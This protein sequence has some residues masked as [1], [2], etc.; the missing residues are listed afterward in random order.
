MK[1]TVCSL[2]IAWEDK[3]KNFEK[4]ESL[5]SQIENPGDLFILPEMFSTGFTMNTALAEDAAGE[6]LKWMISTAE[7]FNI[8]ILG[9]IPSNIIT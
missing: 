9:S 3:Q 8:A 6:T 7:K 1:F 2:D 4:V 5:L